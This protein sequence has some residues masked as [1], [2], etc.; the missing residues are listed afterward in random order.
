MLI[1]IFQAVSGLMDEQEDE[2]ESEDT[3]E[4]CAFGIIRNVNQDKNLF[5]RLSPEEQIVYTRRKIEFILG[6]RA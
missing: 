3:E 5:E 6:I 4:D 2:E 1:Y